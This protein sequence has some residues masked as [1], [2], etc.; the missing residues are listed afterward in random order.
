MLHGF[1]CC[2][3]GRPRRR[4][5]PRSRAPLRKRSRY[6]VRMAEAKTQAVQTI[7][8]TLL[9]AATITPGVGIFEVQEHHSGVI[10]FTSCA[11]CIIAA[12]LIPLTVFIMFPWIERLGAKRAER[13]HDAP[14][15]IQTENKSLSTATEAERIFI[16]T[17]PR[18][19]TDMYGSYT[20]DLEADTAVERYLGKWM[21][22]DGKLDNMYFLGKE[23]NDLMVRIKSEEGNESATGETLKA[24]AQH[25]LVEHIIE[26]EQK[27]GRAR[28]RLWFKNPKSIEQLAVLSHGDSV[29]ALG[30]IV[31]IGA[32]DVRLEDCELIS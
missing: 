9:A 5:H 21:K 31:W 29:K 22:I 3:S 25:G 7:V 24:Q 28:A 10:W 1:Q 30:R 12:V 8:G 27:A 23:K 11:V 14:P 32:Y 19:L 6:D 13:P 26:I 18:F 20:T 4:L 16:D 2:P 15:S 17:S